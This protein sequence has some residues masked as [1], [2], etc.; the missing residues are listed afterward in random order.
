[1]R[2]VKT[3]IITSLLSSWTEPRCHVTTGVGDPTATHVKLAA[4]PGSTSTLSGGIEKCGG[5][6]RTTNTT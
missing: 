6:L 2:A 5:T 3:E 1:M 4:P